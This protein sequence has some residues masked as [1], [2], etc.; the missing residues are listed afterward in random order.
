MES[1]NCTCSSALVP[2]CVHARVYT[3]EKVASGGAHK[4]LTISYV[5]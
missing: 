3:R 4:K 5:P 2:R 1:I